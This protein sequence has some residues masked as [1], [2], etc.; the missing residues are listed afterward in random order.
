MLP[1]KSA[2]QEV[3]ARHMIEILHSDEML[4]DRM[5][6]RSRNKLNGNVSLKHNDLYMTCDSAWYYDDTNQVFAYSNIHIRQGDT[7]H[8]WG[9]Y[10][11]Y[12]GDTGKAVMTDSVELADKET[13][14]YTRKIDYDVNTQI[15]TY[16]DGGRI[17]NGDNTLTSIIGIYYADRKMMHFRDSVKIV[18]PDFVMHADTM[19]YDTYNEIVWF[20]GPTETVGDSI[21]IFCERGWSD[22]KNDVSRLMKNA[23]LDN[24]QQRI[25]GDTLWYDEKN[26]HGEGFGNVT[27]ADTSSNVIC[28][29]NYGWYFKRPEK[30][31]LTRTPWFTMFSDDDTITL[32]ADT[33]RALPLTDTLGVDHRLLKAFYQCTIFSREIQGKCD[34]LSYSFLDSVIRLYDDPVVWSRENQMSADSIALFTRD[35]KAD[36]MELYNSAFVVSSVDTARFDQ[37]SG[38]NLSGYFVDNKLH[39]IKVTGNGDAIYYVVDGKKLVGVNRAKSASI[40]IYIEDGKI[41]EIYQ[42]QSPDG[43]LDPPLKNPASELLLDGFRWLPELRPQRNQVSLRSE[44]LRSEG[45]W[46][47]GPETK[48]GKE[49]GKRVKPN[50]DESPVKVKKSELKL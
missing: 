39:R 5:A 21:Y 37:V 22:T 33:L 12:N 27:I 4:Y 14:L 42:N 40:D 43:T 6:D 36:H 30:F 15:A 38:K 45:P 18:N 16:D 3:P 25:T 10:L 20:E 34:S 2:A 11:S 28:G 8:I 35:R 49:K 32:R 29:G 47:E 44:G 13:R 17:I 41:T 9:N 31:L 1:Y 50:Q 19:R 26:G 24:R 46:S 23:V 48:A 7:I